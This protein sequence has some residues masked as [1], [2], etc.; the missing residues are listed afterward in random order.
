MPQ[1]KEVIVFGFA[2]ALIQL[3]DGILTACGVTFFGTMSEGNPV[4]RNLMEV[5]GHIPALV[6]IKSLALIVIYYLCILSTQVYWIENAL[7]WIIGLYLF[8][9]IIPWSA[10]ICSH[11]FG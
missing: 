8:T 9:A 6:L 7:K 10:I 3:T 5:V 4:V 11:L 1:A 2:L